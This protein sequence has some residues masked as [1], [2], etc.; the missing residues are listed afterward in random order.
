MKNAVVV[1]ACC[2]VGV[3]AVAA[4]Q[5]AG[6]GR[7]TGQVMAPGPARGGPPTTV[8]AEVQSMFNTLKGYIT[9]AADQ[10]P[11][12]SYNWQPKPEVRTW[13]GLISHIVDDNNNACW[14][15]AGDAAKPPALDA[16]GKPTVAGKDLKK[17]DIVKV[18]AESFARC[19]KAFA[20]VTPDTMMERQGS[21]TKIGVLIYDTQHISEHWGNI[22]TYMRLQGMVPPSTAARTGRGRGGL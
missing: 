2:V 15:L 20:A 12:D 9:K 3:A 17:A 22:V 14:T 13:G 11:E 5:G 6:Q 19:D 1:F 18:L 16:D 8:V 21:R 7:A 10:F 4:R